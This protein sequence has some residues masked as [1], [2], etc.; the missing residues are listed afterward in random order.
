MS[1]ASKSNVAWNM[2]LPMPTN[3]KPYRAHTQLSS[4]LTIVVSGSPVR[5][6]HPA[7]YRDGKPCD[8][9]WYPPKAARAIVNKLEKV[10]A[11]SAI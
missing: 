4:R 8:S 11:D 7:R 1:C 2:K 9:D 3:A 5:T 6:V 10:F